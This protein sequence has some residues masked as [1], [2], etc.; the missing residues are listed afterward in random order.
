MLMHIFSDDSKFW[1]YF[2]NSS[3]PLGDQPWSTLKDLNIMRELESAD[4]VILEGSS[5]T[6]DWYPF[7]LTEYYYDHIA[8]PSV[9]EAV[10]Q[11][12]R[13]NSDWLASIKKDKYP[14]GA[15]EDEILTMESK[16]ICR[17]RQT[18]AIKAENGKF[19]SAGGDTDKELIANRDG[20]S[21]WEIYSILYLPNGK[22][23]LY[24]YK[25]K[26]LSAELAQRGELSSTRTH[27]GDWEM[28]T[29]ENPEEG[30]IALKA[31]NGKYVSLDRKS[32]QLISGAN[33]IG[34]SETFEIVK[35]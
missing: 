35:K 32:L 21:D 23:A 7:G 24:S 20:A 6:S 29:I 11:N 31:S 17:D 16:I 28:F 15:S 26:F 5:G 9:L 12:I 18:V 30:K 22:V 14:A 2:A 13:S 8:E 25:N 4:C 33:S 27:I 19:I 1:Y 3:A 34:K 10:K